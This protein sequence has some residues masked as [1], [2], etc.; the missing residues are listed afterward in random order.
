M[1]DPTNSYYQYANPNNLNTFGKLVNTWISDLINDPFAFLF[2]QLSEIDMNYPDDIYA[3][4]IDCGVE[5]VDPEDDFL[6]D[7]GLEI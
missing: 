7:G 4:T 6:I 2:A 5:G 1:A 3:T